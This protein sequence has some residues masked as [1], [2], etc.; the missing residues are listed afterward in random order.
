M[1]PALLEEDRIAV[2]SG[3]AALG[4][5]MLQKPVSELRFD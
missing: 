1:N 5:Y 4:S 2:V 3:A